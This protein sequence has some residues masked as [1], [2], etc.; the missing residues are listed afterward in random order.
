MADDERKSTA[1]DP[2]P[3]STSEA[4]AQ[5]EAA[6][7]ERVFEK[8]LR[9]LPRPAYRCAGQKQH[10]GANFVLVEW[11]TDGARLE[12][13]WCDGCWIPVGDGSDLL[14]AG[15]NGTPTCAK[16]ETPLVDGA[17]RRPV[18]VKVRPC[19]RCGLIFWDKMEV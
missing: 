13:W 2:V 17:Q 8:M 15:A 5:A 7:K 12:N 4:A 11:H 18:V 9:G 6:F 16:C 19:L 14:K 1:L 10:R 3:S